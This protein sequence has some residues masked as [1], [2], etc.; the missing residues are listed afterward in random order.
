MSSRT[1]R[2]PVRTTSSSRSDRYGAHDESR[3]PM[4][5]T[6]ATSSALLIWH[7]MA[8]PSLRP[9]RHDVIGLPEPV[10]RDLD[11][12]TSGGVEV[13]RAAGLRRRA[14]GDRGGVLPP[15]HLGRQEPGLAAV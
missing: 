4:R 1:S 13:D 14:E 10:G 5:T 2:T 6:S 9:D 7:S 11:P 8:I 15:D 3:L 12:V